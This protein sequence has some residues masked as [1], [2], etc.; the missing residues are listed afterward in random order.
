M[1][2]HMMHIN[3]IYVQ[4]AYVYTILLSLILTSSPLSPGTPGAPGPPGAP[5]KCQQKNSN[6]AF[7]ASYE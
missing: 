2:L 7:H 6:T 4:I 1:C 3:S 5:Y